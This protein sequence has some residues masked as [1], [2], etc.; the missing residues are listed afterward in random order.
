MMFE[1]GL[2]GYD[3]WLDNYG[4]PGMGDDVGYDW[5]LTDP[6]VIVTKIS[7][8]EFLIRRYNSPDQFTLTIDP[9]ADGERYLFDGEYIETESF[10]QWVGLLDQF[11]EQDEQTAI[12]GNDNADH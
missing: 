11:G 12:I 5:A 6:K 2:P 7:D 3:S 9:M 10:V 1:K 4:N 8:I